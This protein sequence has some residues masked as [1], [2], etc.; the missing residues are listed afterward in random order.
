[1]SLASDAAAKSAYTVTVPN[2]QSQRLVVS[3]FDWRDRTLSEEFAPGAGAGLTL[4]AKRS[5]D[6]FYV[7]GA[8]V[9]GGRLYALS[10]AFS[11][12]L[13]IDLATHQVVAAHAIAGLDRPTGLAIKGDDLCIACANGRVVTVARPVS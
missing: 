11:T 9:E 6:E 8:A 13:T 3:R 1:M 4:R 10:A 5:L 12:L 7:T 2:S